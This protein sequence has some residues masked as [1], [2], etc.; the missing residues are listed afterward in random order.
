MNCLGATLA[1]ESFG[2]MGKF[3]A[4]THSS[5]PGGLSWLSNFSQYRNGFASA[6]RDEFHIQSMRYEE[7]A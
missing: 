5:F 6:L 4:L 2:S 1:G 3:F 7:R